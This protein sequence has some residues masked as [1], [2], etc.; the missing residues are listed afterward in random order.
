MPPPNNRRW[1]RSA[2]R[3]ASQL[4]RAPV[5]SV[6]A[7][8]LAYE[9]SRKRSRNGD[10]RDGNTAYQHLT[11]QGSSRARL[12]MRPSSDPFPR[13]LKHTFETMSHPQTVFTNTTIPRAL[14]SNLGLSQ[15]NIA[16]IALNGTPAN[17]ANMLATVSAAGLAAQYETPQ[18]WDQLTP[19]YAHYQL[20]WAKYE[21][22]FA[23][24]STTQDVILFWLIASAH[25]LEDNTLRDLTNAQD[26]VERLQMHPHVKCITMPRSNAA[27][28]T[29]SSVTI[30]AFLRRK[31][32]VSKAQYTVDKEAVWQ[33]STTGTGAASTDA[34]VPRFMIWA[35]DASSFTTVLGAVTLN[36]AKASFNVSMF[37][38]ELSALAGDNP[39]A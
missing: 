9:P 21:I 15:M 23:N 24:A 16:Q 25:D 13:Y 11:Q 26:S 1:I 4:F 3:V 37:G 35:F 33:Q 8:L 29:K 31:N 18:F 14:I 36:R 39:V 6:G 32:L 38:R 5:G 30:K 22:T 10:P 27:K 28:P 2:G 34:H 17:E 12:C 7:G 19:L 20:N